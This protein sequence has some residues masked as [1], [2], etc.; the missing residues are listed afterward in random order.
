MPTTIAWTNETWNPV[1]GC[2]HVSAGCSHCYAE[3]LSLRRGWSRKPWTAQ[4][5]AENVVLHPER[6]TKP[7]TYRPG[8][9]VFVNSM[10]DMFHPR[11]PFSFVDAI[12]DVMASRRDVFFQCLTKRPERAA[13]WSG[14]W[15]PNVWMGTTVE[16][17]RVLHRIEY[18]QRIPAALRFLSCEPL[19]GP[20]DGVDL[21]G[22]GWVI[23][24]GESGPH[25]RPFDMA[26]ARNL[27]DRCVASGV[28]FFFKQ[29]AGFR[30]E[31]RPWIEELDG[32]HTTWREY[33]S[34]VQTAPADLFS[35]AA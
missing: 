29:Q 21:T 34:H 27:R 31:T 7:R 2:S 32:Q 25:H 9:R 23:C 22:I 6:L 33:P 30:T 14:H 8:T 5:A 11:V 19:L 1:T 13:Q 15:L 18:L 28:P 35:R 17:A 20:L 24:G 12:F 3:A 10:S 16:D 4:N 26:W